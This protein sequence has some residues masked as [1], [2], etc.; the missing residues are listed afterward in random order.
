[1]YIVYCILYMDKYKPSAANNN[2][3]ISVG[4]DC[5]KTLCYTQIKA[6][7][8]AISYMINICIYMY[9]VMYN[10]FVVY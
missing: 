5:R 10:A 1:M 8:W 2:K 4:E 3:K 7:L 6:N 9:I